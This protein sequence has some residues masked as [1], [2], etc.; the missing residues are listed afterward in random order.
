MKNG[1]R[2][3]RNQ[4]K[5]LISV[6]LSPTKWLVFKAIEGELHL[7]HRETGRTKIVPAQ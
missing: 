4:S 5:A 1:K 3:T 2:P 6:G 7:V